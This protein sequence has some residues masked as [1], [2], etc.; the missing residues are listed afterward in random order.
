MTDAPADPTPD[1]T[2]V[3]VTDVPE[4]SRYTAT[5]D[6]RTAGFAEYQRT[7]ELV[8]FTHTEVDRAWEGRGVGA[9]LVRQSLDDVRDSGLKVLPLCPFYRQWLGRHP[10]YTD[11]VY[12]APRSTARD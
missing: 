10:E 8:V 1:R 3:T 4:Q 12:D 7:H 2:P 11:L 6:G 9:A 5:V